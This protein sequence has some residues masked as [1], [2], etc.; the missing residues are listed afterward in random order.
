MVNDSGTV[1]CTFF[2]TTSIY[3]TDETTSIFIDAF[4]TRPPLEK[5]AHG[6]IAPDVD[7][8]KG[9]LDQA[10]IRQLD[11]LFVAHSHFDHVM[12]SPT[13]VKL[14]GGRMYGSESTLNVGRGESLKD[15]SMQIIK[16]GD[17]FSIGAFRVRIYEGEHSPGNIAPGEITSPLKPPAT[18]KDYR[19]GGCYSFFIQHP[20]GTILIHPSANYVQDRF[21]GL[22]TDVLYLG[23]GVLGKQSPE[24][25][26]NYWKETVE[27]TQPKLVLPIHWD[28]F[29]EPLSKPLQPLPST[30][31][32]FELTKQLIEKKSDGAAYKV[33]W[34]GAYETIHPFQALP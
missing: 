31:D 6:T 1:P 22:K 23:V 30:L 33:R 24:F 5:L 21:K 13:V 9:T 29:G 34:Q 11:G 2:G 3:I 10:G 27:A 12:D 17:E 15:D 19:D 4:L 18:S 16:D 14:L 20:E 26:D 7:I 8:I 25:Q 28:N 32:D